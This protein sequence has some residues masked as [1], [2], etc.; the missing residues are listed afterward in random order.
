[1]LFSLDSILTQTEKSMRTG[2]AVVVSQEHD[3]G[4]IKPAAPDFDPREF[5]PTADA[6]MNY[7]IARNECNRL[8]S[9]N[10]GA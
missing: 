9:Q 1:M 8:N 4:K 5:A 7:D 10:L 2:A 6:K 3:M